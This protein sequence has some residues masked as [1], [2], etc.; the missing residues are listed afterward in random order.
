M[1]S[2]SKYRPIEGR[3]TV[4][5]LCAGQ[6]VCISCFPYVFKS[7]GL[8]CVSATL[9]NCLF[10]S[11]ELS[12]AAC[13][14]QTQPGWDPVT[15]VSTASSAPCPLKQ[16]A[17]DTSSAC[18]E[19][20]QR[21]NC[22][23]LTILCS[24]DNVLEDK[25]LILSG[26]NPYHHVSPTAFYPHQRSPEIRLPQKLKDLPDHRWISTMCSQNLH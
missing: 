24:T 12:T 5:N 4:L 19:P 23:P 25:Q 10:A 6:G 26:N 22:P 9:Y 17:G 8:P 7:K 13:G 16:L 18:P 20:G 1:K 21:Q 11:Q 2:K 14:S 15:Y 3:L